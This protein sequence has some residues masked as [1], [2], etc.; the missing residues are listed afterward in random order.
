MQHISWSQDYSTSPHISKPI[1]WTF[2]PSVNC[3]WQYY[4]T[5]K[6]A[7][8]SEQFYLQNNSYTSKSK[9]AFSCYNFLTSTPVPLLEIP[10][11]TILCFSDHSAYLPNAL[12]HSKW[13]Y[14]RGHLSLR[15]LSS[16]VYSGQTAL[17]VSGPSIIFVD[18]NPNWKDV[19]TTNPNTNLTANR[20]TSSTHLWSKLYQ[21]NNTNEQL[22]DV[23]GS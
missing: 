9:M 15:S 12:W 16:T 10:F 22:V 5:S 20:P 6:S 23:K 14:Q 8:V 7:I 21:S 18:N 3:V 2:T 11:N 1:L 17:P 19:P 4:Q 13:I